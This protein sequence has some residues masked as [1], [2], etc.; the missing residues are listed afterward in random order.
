MWLFT[1]KNRTRSDFQA[2]AFP[3]YQDGT[4]IGHLGIIS[5]NL[6]RQP[7]FLLFD[8]FNVDTL[9]KLLITN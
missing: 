4:H 2:L 7:K 8:E 9:D 5:G 6:A 1:A 3:D